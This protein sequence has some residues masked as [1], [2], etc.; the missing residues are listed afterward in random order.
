MS[1]AHSESAKTLKLAAGLPADP[2]ALRDAP[3]DPDPRRPPGKLGL[4]D[5]SPT[6]D[7]ISHMKTPPPKRWLA[8]QAGVRQPEDPLKPDALARFN[9]NKYIVKEILPNLQ[10]LHADLRG[11][12]QAKEELLELIESLEGRQRS[13][14]S[15]IDHQQ[16]KTLME[17][18][19]LE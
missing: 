14:V 19:Q 5:P 10:G 17:I 8:H 18:E 7:Y 1:F 3:A 6:L 4:A 2:P 12:L 9:E 16:T 15:K 13:L 11:N